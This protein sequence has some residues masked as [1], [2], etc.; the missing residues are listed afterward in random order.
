MSR[1]E[2]GNVDKQL[3]RVTVRFT[4]GEF[5]GLSAAASAAYLPVASFIRAA[6]LDGV[7]SPVPM[8]LTAD[9]RAA[10]EDLNGMLS[11]LSQIANHAAEAGWNPTASRLERA[12]LAAANLKIG[13]AAN[14]P[15][16]FGLGEAGQRLNSLARS[17]NK[18]QLVTP[19]EWLDHMHSALK[20]LG[21]A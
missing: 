6:L 4:Q 11:N 20:I 14:A 21:E 8:A 3:C 9:Q 13:V 7:P 15:I 10:I 12:A 16:P 5:D 17:L 18:G 1:P 2:K 19:Q